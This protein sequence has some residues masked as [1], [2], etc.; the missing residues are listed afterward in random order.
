MICDHRAAVT[1]KPY[2]ENSA[3][4]YDRNLTFD[5]EAFSCFRDWDPVSLALA[6]FAPQPTNLPGSRRLISILSPG[7]LPK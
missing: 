4:S 1:G 2:D 6:R 3:V 5:T 7:H